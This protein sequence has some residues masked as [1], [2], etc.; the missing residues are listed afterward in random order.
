VR[1]RVV[2]TLALFCG[3]MKSARFV[4]S[5]A[6]QMGVDPDDVRAVEFRRTDVARPAS[7]YTAQ[8]SLRDGGERLRDWWNLA[9]GDWGAGFFQASACDYC[10]DVVGE[11]ADASFGDAWVE[12]HS[13]D[14]RGTSVAVVRSRRLDRLLHD[15]VAHG[16]LALSPVDGDFV[17]A[18]QAAGLRQRREGLAYRLAWHRRRPRPTKRVGASR[19][20]PFG[21]K[22]VYRSRHLISVWSHRM[23]WFARVTRRPQLYVRWARAAATAYH[24]VAYSRGRLGAIV[25]RLGVRG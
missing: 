24:A 6:W 18:T 16:G 8:L 25:G 12:P 13:S 10:D 1:E 11:T 22:V 19:D 2:V 14:G 4:D 5:I 3:H 17:E 15:G 7:T 21:R 23:W 9:D 20:L